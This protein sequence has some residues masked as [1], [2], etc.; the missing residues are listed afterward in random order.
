MSEGKSTSA[1]LTENLVTPP[2]QIEIT[3][4]KVGYK[5]KL[6][7]FTK[8]TKH[9]EQRISNLILYD[10][11]KKNCCMFKIFLDDDIGIDKKS[12]GYL[13][14]TEMD[15]DCQSSDQIING[16]IRKG[17]SMLNDAVTKRKLK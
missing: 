14:L 4:Q 1:D 6:R 9:R 5:R 3:E 17:I 10:S 12:Q 8:G 16:G 2:K 15:D 7:S 13:M 11:S